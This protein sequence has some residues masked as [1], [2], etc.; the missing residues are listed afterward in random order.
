MKILVV[1]HDYLPA[2][3]GGSELH[4]H[5]T[6]VELA[7]RGH[8]VTALFTERDLSAEQGELRR[9]ELDGVATIEAVHQR[10]YE[11]VRETWV[12]ARSAEV[13]DRVLDELRPDVVHFHHLAL[14]GSRC[15]RVARE[16]GCR[17]LLTLHDYHLVCDRATLLRSDGELCTGG[18]TGDCTD[19]LRDHPLLP[20]RH[21]GGAHRTPEALLALAAIAR[22]EQHA[23]DL[24]SVRRVICP[25]R[26]LADLFVEAELL[27][28]EQVVVLEAGYPGPRR[29]P[30]PAPPADGP[31][32]PLRVGYV[33]GIYPSKGLHVL[34]DAMGHL[35]DA[36][37]ELHVHGILDWFPDYVDALRRAATG[38][39]VHFHGR[40]EPARL[41]DVLAGVDVLVVP[42]VWYE[43]MP[44][45]IQE[46][47]R[48][49]LPVV[50]TDLGGMAEAVEHGVSGLTFPRGDAR[51]LADRLR[52]LAS[53]RA[54]L[55]RLA[56][57]RPPITTLEE[58]V[59]ELERLY[60]P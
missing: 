9:G 17:V 29:E 34:V 43:N 59:D 31:A 11:D 22:R 38:L 60:A 7:R 40:F 42:S 51:A 6:A 35:R 16:A 47:F 19:C 2:H 36:P 55:A 32:T 5:Q 27:R 50:T 15:L 10:E 57:G 37:V 1:V 18:P 24:A 4:A 52:A 53:D 33:G 49:G 13:L 45:T 46:A 56:A 28:P 25:S 26:F 21:P 14:W 23:N 44:I 30:R 54:L 58:V 39:P 48:N 41:D 20:E 8:E 12:Q 3:L